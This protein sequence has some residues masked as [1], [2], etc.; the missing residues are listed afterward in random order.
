MWL[1]YL[2][3]Y[4][5]TLIAFATGAGVGLLAVR[6]AV[7]RRADDPTLGAPLAPAAEHP[8]ASGTS[9]KVEADA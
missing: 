1:W 4:L 5:L 8:A 7:R 2:E 9:A 3:L 6:F